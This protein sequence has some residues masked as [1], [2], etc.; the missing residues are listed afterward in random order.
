MSQEKLH[1]ADRIPPVRKGVS[2]TEGFFPV[3]ERTFLV[4]GNLFPVTGLKFT[5]W[6]YDR[7]KS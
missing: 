5:S 6:M 1:V 3:K 2:L 4:T 7:L